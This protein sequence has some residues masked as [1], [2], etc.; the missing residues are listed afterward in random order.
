MTLEQAYARFND[1]FWGE[2]LP[3]TDYKSVIDEDWKDGSA[4]IELYDP[5]NVEA[6]EFFIKIWYPITKK[7]M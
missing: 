3:K 7:E 2:W 5:P 4:S 6:T 1:I